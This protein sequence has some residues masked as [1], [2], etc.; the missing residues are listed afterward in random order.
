MRY[1][2][3]CL[4][5]SS[6]DAH[7]SPDGAFSRLFRR[8]TTS[9]SS[10]PS[11]SLLND[12]GTSG[13]HSKAPQ[14]PPTSPPSRSPA[15]WMKPWTW[16]RAPACECCASAIPKGGFLA[17]CQSGL[18][19][20]GQP[21]SKFPTASFD[22]V[23]DSFGLCSHEDPVQVLQEASRV[24]KP[25]GRILLLEHGRAHYDF[26]NARLDSSAEAHHQKW[27]CYWNRDIN[28]II[29]QVRPFCPFVIVT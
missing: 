1:L 18:T 20:D 10:N 29:K 7:H 16:F 17:R 13:S 24:C 28:A 8:T 15:S 9:D 14:S 25:N 27:G 6:F 2:L 4:L 21:L 19:D 22:T 3:S 26:L 5:L 23:V 12:N 11:S